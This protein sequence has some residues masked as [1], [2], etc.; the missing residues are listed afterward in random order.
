M[1]L[2]FNTNYFK[3]KYQI[4]KKCTKLYYLVSIFHSIFKW[5]YNQ[6]LTIIINNNNV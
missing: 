1:N 6:N 4:K 5:Y 2:C 3:I